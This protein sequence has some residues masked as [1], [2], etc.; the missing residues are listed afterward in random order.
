MG[1]ESSMLTSVLQLLAATFL[2][3]MLGIERVLAGRTAGPRTYALVSVGACLLTIMSINSTELYPNASKADPVSIVAA[4]VS[5]IGF[6]GAGLII[7]RNSKLSGLTT[8]AGIWVSA[9]I[10]ITVGFRYFFLAF[11]ATFLTL[12]IFTI[13][14]QIERRIKD[15]YGYSFGKFV[16][17]HKT[18]HHHKK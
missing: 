18:E 6:L 4:V 10:G 11:F 17:R 3:M 8:A 13:M 14:W 16:V 9:A 2:G 15:K 1:L 12:F 5:G 7:F